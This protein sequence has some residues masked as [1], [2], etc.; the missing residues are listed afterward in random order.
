M[1]DDIFILIYLI[2]LL[3]KCLFS[4][5]MNM[6]SIENICISG[7]KSRCLIFHLISNN[8]FLTICFWCSRCSSSSATFKSNQIC[9]VLVFGSGFLLLLCFL[10]PRSTLPAWKP[11]YVKQQ[12]KLIFRIL[13]NS[14]SNGFV[15]TCVKS[16]ANFS[17]FFHNLPIIQDM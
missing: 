5:N 11:L 17:Y 14:T 13:H 6:T 15:T 3:N 10:Q 9:Q 2:I 12:I 7:K 1:G 8:F 4:I 16:N